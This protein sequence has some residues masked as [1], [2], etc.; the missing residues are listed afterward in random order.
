MQEGGA[1]SAR[2][3]P[4]APRKR[5]P[6]SRNP[7]PWHG[8]C[9]SFG[10]SRCAHQFDKFPTD[11]PFRSVDV[12]GG[13]AVGTWI[14]I[15]LALW[16]VLFSG[17]ALAAQTVNGRLVDGSSDTPI[18]QG[19]VVLMTVGGD[20]VG[21]TLSDTEGRFSISTEQTGGFLLSASAWGYQSSVD[22]VFELGADGVIDIE[23]RLLP[24]PMPLDSILVILDRP[25]SLDPKVVS[26]GF[27]RRM[28]YGFGRFITP[29]EIDQSPALSTSELLDRVPG[30]SLRYRS[31]VETY[32]GAG[33]VLDG[34]IGPC[35]PR[36]YIDGVIVNA[37]GHIDGVVPLSSLEA[38][39]IYRR[40]VQVPMQFA[41]SR[42][43]GEDDQF[44][45]C[46]VIVL[47]T[48]AR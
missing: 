13:K 25:S 35:V 11:D 48:K 6:G 12:M 37:T 18:A 38:A 16:T 34:P 8:R 31:N 46:G 22:G 23:Y 2:R 14:T 42:T 32:A 19:Q 36:L 7:G 41:L 28:Q 10:H 33:L 4:Y 40:P 17:D 29:H 3:P 9:S 39:E 15:T 5:G 45:P 26:S 44:N 24:A 43:A 47:W 27:V 21:A 20:T 1:R 30:V